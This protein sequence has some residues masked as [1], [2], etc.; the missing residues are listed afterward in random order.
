MTN[1]PGDASIRNI[2]RGHIKTGSMK[3]ALPRELS[4]GG[5]YLKI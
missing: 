1:L 5:K 2:E 4:A 3:L